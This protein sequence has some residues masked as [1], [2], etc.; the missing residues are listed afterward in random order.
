MST[1][2]PVIGRRERNKQQKLQ[3]IIA[4]ASELFAAH[5]VDEVTTQQI[6]ERAD[7]GTG[8][9]FLYAKNKGELLLLVQNANYAVALESGIAAAEDVTDPAD[10]IMALLRPIIDCNRTHV[11]NGRSYLREMVFGDPTDAHHANALRIVR[12]TEEA[13]VAILRRDPEMDAARAESLARIFSAI[14]FLT[15]GASATAALSV[16]AIA[17][18]VR[19]QVSAVLGR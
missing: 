15:M 12:A 16:D 6:A 2:G 9:L 3:R 5:G 17:A 8:T 10:A 1:A 13:S 18:D 11:D 7:I 4:A 14:M 19:T